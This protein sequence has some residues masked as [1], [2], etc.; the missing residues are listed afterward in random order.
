M[1]FSFKWSD[2]PIYEDGHFFMAFSLKKVKTTKN[3]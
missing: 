1:T 2:M 3:L